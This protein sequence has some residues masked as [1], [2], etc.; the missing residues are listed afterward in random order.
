MRRNFALIFPLALLFLGLA[1]PDAFATGATIDELA[2]PVE[3]VVNTLRG[4]LG[5]LFSLF[6]LIGCALG[7]YWSR[8]EELSGFLKQLIS[9]V[10]IITII[11]FAAQVLDF[12][13][14]FSGAVL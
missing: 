12:L 7:Y 11:A 6:M 13:F 9:T 14:S 4:P 10:F 3:K 8:G 2:G 5:K 1:A